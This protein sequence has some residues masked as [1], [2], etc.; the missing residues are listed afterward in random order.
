MLRVKNGDIQD[1]LEK[2]LNRLTER[3][4]DLGAEKIILFGS[5]ARGR[6]DALTDLDLIVVMES[7]EPFVRRAALVYGALVPRVAADI[8]VYTPGEW[9]EVKE[10]PF[11]KKALG[12][13]RILYEKRAG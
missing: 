5:Y 1:V 2:E 7:G 9:R 6:C 13:G 3:L 12:E 8:L 4:I 10:R 11:I